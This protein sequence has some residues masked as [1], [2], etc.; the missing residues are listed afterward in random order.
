MHVVYIQSFIEYFDAVQALDAA[1]EDALNSGNLADELR[2]E[3]AF[4]NNKWQTRL[5]SDAQMEFDFE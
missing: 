5:I 1:F 2:G 3:V 4:I